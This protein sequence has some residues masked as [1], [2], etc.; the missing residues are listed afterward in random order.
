MKGTVSVILA[1]LIFA[2][3]I[4]YSSKNRHWKEHAM[5]HVS[6]AFLVTGL[7]SVQGVLLAQHVK[8]TPVGAR[9]GEFC[10]P[11]RALILEDPT[12][13]RILYDPA[14]TVAGGSDS[15][16]GRID[17]ILISHAH[18]DH[19]GNAKLNQDPKDS[20]ARCDSAPTVPT[21]DTNLAEIAVMKGAAVIGSGEL[22]AFLGAKIQH[23]RSGSVPGCPAA[24]PINELIVP[25]V[26][27]PCIGS[28]GYGA[29]RTL[30]SSMASEGVQIALVAAL[31]GNG[32]SNSLLADP[33]ASELMTNGLT[34][35][36]GTASG[37]VVTF[38]NGLRV[39]LSGDTG[40]TSDMVTVVRGYYHA[41]LAVFN[42]GDIF[43][44][45]PEEA[46]FAIN[47]LIRPASV[48]PSHAN[49]V[50]TSGGIV[51]PGTKTG[52]FIQLVDD[53]AVYPPLSDITMEFDGRGRCVRGCST[54]GKQ[55]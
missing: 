23:L 13:V 43:T 53:A 7:L 14:T 32:I 18:P 29:K 42:I 20:A 15:R 5:K 46:A 35:A 4:V 24:G 3:Q 36:P 45:G 12:G 2:S 30:R 19:V 49:E 26:N 52:R 34:F 21:P 9:Y 44:T 33:L 22:T 27:G 28:L 8:I 48:I 11:D 1:G 39:Y 17:A 38:T 54:N 50:A 10:S 25:V 37:F 55:H 40:Q 51:N 47:E 31:H 16:L 41:N 6:F